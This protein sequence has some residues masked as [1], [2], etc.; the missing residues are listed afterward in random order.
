MHTANSDNSM[1]ETPYAEPVQTVGPRASG[2]GLNWLGLLVAVLALLASSWLW[3]RSDDSGEQAQQAEAAQRNQEIQQ[4][5]NQVAALQAQLGGV[6]AEGTEARIASLEQGSAAQKALQDS[7]QSFQAESAAWTRS[8]QA[9]IEGDQARIAGLESRFAALEARQGGSASELDL[10]EIDYV[11]RL[12]QER[13]QLFGDSRS[14]DRALALADQQVAG[15]DSPMFIGLRRELAAAREALAGMDQPD[16]VAISADLDEVQSG[17]STL[18]FRGQGQSPAQATPAPEETGWWAR[19]K[20]S[21]GG[22]VTVRRDSEVEGV[23]PVLADQEAI[24]QNAWMQLDLARL[25]VMRRDQPAFAA[26]LER[27]QLLVQ[28]WFEA[29]DAET[30]AL[31]QSLN[32][33]QAINVDPPV[34]DISAPWAALQAIRAGGLTVPAAAPPPAA[35]EEAGTAVESSATDPAPVE[36]GR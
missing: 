20:A 14:A 7:L 6:D 2:A 30:V 31:M 25:A 26:S 34:A 15:Y 5:K 8:M 17:L 1:T 10:A 19:I 18:R 24:R 22:L 29:S 28:R 23:T 33:L 32:R 27:C 16:L 13:L 36:D 4:L 9:A 11:L 35:P 12:A 3:W 21:F